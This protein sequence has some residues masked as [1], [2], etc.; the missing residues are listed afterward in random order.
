MALF[1]PWVA[2]AQTTVEI[3]DGTATTNTN[4]IGTYYNY[5]ITEQLY[6]ADEIGT[7]GTISSI[8]FYYM[9]LAAKDLPITVY[10]QNVDAEDLSTG[11][12]LA[13]ADEVYN[14]T[15]SV[16]TTAGWVTIDLDTPFAYDGRSNL[17]IGII[18]D[19]LY[20]FSGQSWQGTSVSNMARYTQSDGSGPYTTSTVPGSTAAVRPNIQ[21]VITAGSGSVCDKPETFEVSNVTTNSATLTWTG[22]SGTYNVEYKGGSVQD[23]TAYLTNTTATTANLTGLT[24]GTNYQYRVQSICSDGTSG[25]KSVSFSTMFGIPL[26]EEFGT[27]I[28]SGWSIYNGLVENVL[29]GGDL[30][31]ASYGWSFGSNN[32]VFDNHARVNI[33]GTSCNN[34]LVLPTLDM[35]DNVQLMFDVAYTAYSGTGAPAQT[36]EDDKFVVL[37]NNGR[38]WEIMRQWDNAGSE[39]VLND[40]NTTPI[41]VAINLSNYAEA[42]QPITV[43]F[44]GESTVSNADNNLHIDNV[45]IDY[46]PACPKPNGLAVNYESGTT[47][48]VTWN[49][50]AASYQLDVNGT[51]YTSNT[52]SYN[53]TGLE[54]ATTYEVKVRGNCGSDG[55]SEWTN[56]VSF[57]T[58]NCMPEDMCALTFVLSDS[59]GDSWNGASIGVY[60]Y[61]GE[62]VGDLLASVTISSSLGADV[63]QTTTLSFCNGQELAIIWTAGSYD[64]ECSYTITDLNGDI[65]AQDDFDL[66]LAYTVDCTETDCRRPSDFVASEIGPHSVVLS[67]T[68]NGPATSWVIAYISENDEEITEITVNTNPYTLTGLTPET[69]YAAQV[70]PVCDVDKPSEIV[71]WTTDVACPRPTNLSAVPYPNSANLTWNGFAD[72]YDLEWALMP[73]SGSKDALWLQYDNGTVVTNVGNSTVYEWTW[74]VMYPADMLQGNNRLSKVAFYETSYYSEGDPITINIYSGGD[75]EPGTLVYTENVT[76]TGTVGIHEVILSSFVNIDPAQNLWITL[77]STT[78]D[79]PMAMSAVDEANG[80][81]VDNNGSWIDLGTALASVSTYTFMIRGYVEPGF[82]PEELDWNPVSGITS[83][84]TLEG[85]QPETTYVVR[86]KANC[87]GDDGESDWTMITFTTP[88]VCDMPNTFNAEV[89][90]TSATLSW[91]GYQES[92]NLKYRSL[93]KLENATLTENF[94]E[95]MGDWTTIDADGDGYTW[96]SS[97]NPGD[98]HN[99][100]VDLTGNGHNGSAQFVISGSYS[101]S[102]GAALTPDNYLVSP[103]IELGGGIEFWVKAQDAGYFAEHFGVAVSTSGN[104]DAADFTTI[105]EWTLEDGNDWHKY[106]VDLSAY[107]GQGYVAIRHFNCTDMFILNLDDI[108]FGPVVPASD[109]IVVEETNT[110]YVLSTEPNTTYE[111][112][113]Q[114]VS[115]ECTT[116]W[117]EIQSFTTPELTTIEQPI[118]LNTGSNYVSFY[119]DI[120]MDELKAAIQAA[121]VGGNVTIK[122]LNSGQ[123]MY[124]G[125]RWRG[126]LNTLNMSEMYMIVVSDDADAMEISVEGMPIDPASYPINIAAGT[127]WFA[128][129]LSE[130]MT[131]ADAF[132]EFDAVNG[133]AIKSSG[134]GQATY[135]NRWRGALTTLQPGVGYIFKAADA[136]TEARPLVFP[137]PRKAGN[138]KASF[139][140]QNVDKMALKTVQVKTLDLQIS[141]PE[142]ANVPSKANQ[143]N[144]FHDTVSRLFNKIH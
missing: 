74:A 133:D 118:T 130:P 142:R 40:L 62:E 72:A 106:V 105:A 59:Y 79:R 22:G 102:L 69:A 116:E 29:A 128:F 87:G 48:T 13:D 50:D 18:K 88:S 141:K 137:T 35:E 110:P 112:Q 75:S 115:R 85:L 66:A 80:R 23:W 37:V 44:Y 34:W 10:M 9:G 36:G 15:L 8:S 124:N 95:G 101:N 100:G 83:P 65:V 25:W 127:T 97:M 131:V 54:L 92:F 12:S 144:N 136:V 3:G 90:A 143:T 5:S 132:A 45:S 140:P 11:I 43:A 86:V 42:G 7:A 39:Y 81:W 117:S 71:Y 121:Y 84:Y 122:S 104:T 82:D 77:T 68:E 73:A 129:Q 120:T 41:T 103:Q 21:M 114:G 70:T 27:A 19:Y 63:E 91:V 14:G 67:W 109:W 49:G 57:K 53:L 89:E 38:S 107:T 98:Y 46:I 47:A 33:Y 60:D 134:S 64:S 125:A 58:D 111:W 16:T 17:L 138:A 32:G 4:P 61:T 56:T 31:T 135:N 108:S 139:M 126:S 55:Y 30:T 113:V 96:V 94:D 123:T 78:I 1:T 93:A 51:T 28:P 26:V 76:C 119:V 24:P 2:N 20:Y 6:T 52:N 99:A